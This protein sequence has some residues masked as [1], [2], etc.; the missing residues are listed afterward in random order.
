MSGRSSKNGAD[1]E[2]HGGDIELG[3]KDYRFSDLFDPI[4]LASLTEEFYRSVEASD[5]IL[6]EALRAYIAARG[7]GY[8]ARAESNKI[9]SAAPHLSAFIAKLFDVEA[10]RE[11]LQLQVLGQDPIWKLKF[12]IQRR[13]IKKYNAEAS[14]ALDATSLEKTVLS[15]SS[16][17]SKSDTSID[18]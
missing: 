5:S 15:L 3:I 10:E 2:P 18:E 13:A 4:C 17:V 16:S 1:I 12:F 6:G 8:E 7:E 11:R 9:T 14:A